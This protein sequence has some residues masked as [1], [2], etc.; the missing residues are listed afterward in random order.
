MPSVPTP[1][2]PCQIRPRGRRRTASRSC[3][4]PTNN[5]SISILIPLGSL[6]LVPTKVKASSPGWVRRQA[7]P[8][9]SPWRQL[10][11]QEPQLQPKLQR[12]AAPDILQTLG[13]SHQRSTNIDHAG[14]S[15]GDSAWTLDLAKSRLFWN[16][17]IQDHHPTSRWPTPSRQ[18]QKEESGSSEVPWRDNQTSGYQP[19]LVLSFLFFSQGRLQEELAGI[20][21]P[22]HRW[23]APLPP[24]HSNSDEKSG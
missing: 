17:T 22:N 13:Y 12:S 16:P 1:T 8:W 20:E 3:L 6:G 11:R 5:S 18:D 24:C 9:G 7:Q 2:R 23:E 14:G 10:L 4:T 21:S 19:W 15:T